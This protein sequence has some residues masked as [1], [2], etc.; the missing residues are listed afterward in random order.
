MSPFINNSTGF[1]A[2][3]SNNSW[4]G[5]GPGGPYGGIA[6]AVP[7]VVQAEHYDTG[8]PGVGY[9]VNAV[10]GTANGYRSDGVDLEATTDAGG[11]YDVGWTAAGQWFRYTV[12]AAS[13]GTYTLRFRVAAPSAVTG[14]L[15]LADSSGTNLTGNLNIPATGS[16]QSWTTVTV[17]LVLPAGQQVLTLVQDRGG[18]NINS[19][20]FVTSEA[21]YGGI[22]AAVPGVVQAEHY[23]I[24]GQGVGYSV[25]AVY[26]G[27]ANGYRPDG[28]DL[29]TTM[30]AGGGYNV[31]WTAAGQWFRYTVNVASAGTYTLRVRVAAPSA[32]GG[33]LHVANGSGTNLTGGVGVPGTG[34]WQVWTTV[35]VGLVLPAGQQVLT[36]VQD[37]GGWN[38]NSLQFATGGEPYGGTPAAV[39]GVVQAEHYDAGGQGVGYSV[40]AVYG[41]TNGYR[42]DGVDL[43]TTTDA[44]GGYNVGWTAPGQWFRYTVNVASAGTYTLRV[45]VA[46]PS[47]VTGAMH[48]ADTSGTNLTGNLNIPATGGWQTWTT[49]TASLTLPAG[50]QVLTIVQDNG[51]WNI[52]NLQFE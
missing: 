35:T 4:Q 47:A 21:P 2:T 24:G 39:P 44:G 33:A 37:S 52:N 49:I 7:G 36:L 34:G 12:N 19:L 43:Q 42:P 45:R 13:A 30:D 1:T 15:H 6:P 14:A 26:G 38:I 22:P 29:Q 27:S 10:N 50:Q 20:Q 8:G 16:W 46:A 28:V 5:G 31:G 9:R 41:S 18:W 3:V 40:N 17:G 51:G 23:D 48:L 32:V 11:G 25:N